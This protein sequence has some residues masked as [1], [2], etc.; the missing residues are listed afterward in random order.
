MSKCFYQIKNIISK[1]ST[2]CHH[3]KMKNHKGRDKFKFFFV[4]GAGKENTD[5][6]S[7]MKGVDT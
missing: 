5:C 7:D 3:H 4:C 1:E 6:K 2:N